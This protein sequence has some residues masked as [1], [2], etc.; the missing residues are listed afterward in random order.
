M[1]HDKETLTFVVLQA[2]HPPKYPR[3]FI[4]GPLR[5]PARFNLSPWE[6]VA[7]DSECLFSH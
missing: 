7:P 4:K 2:H 3:F 5:L 6:G 1:E